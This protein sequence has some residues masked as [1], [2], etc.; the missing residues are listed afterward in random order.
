MRRRSLQAGVQGDRRAG[1][2]LADGA[3]VLRRLRRLLEAG[4]VEA[5]DL[6]A[7]DELDVGDTEAAGGVG[8]AALWFRAPAAV[9]LLLAALVCAALRLLS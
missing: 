4:R 6:A 1:Q 8:A 9:A 7:H 2:G 3:A 5:L